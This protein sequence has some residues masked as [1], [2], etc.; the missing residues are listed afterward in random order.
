[1]ELSEQLEVLDTAI[2]LKTSS[3]H[4]LAVPRSGD[5]TT[6]YIHSKIEHLTEAQTKALLVTYIHRVLELR[7]R[8]DSQRTKELEMT[9]ELDKQSEEMSVMEQSLTESNLDKELKIT[10]LQKVR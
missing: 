4:H 5:D 6:A 3:L 8:L 7:Q 2:Q 10:R 9:E 1:M